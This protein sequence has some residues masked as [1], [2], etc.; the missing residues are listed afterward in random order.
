MVVSH[1]TEIN[2]QVT[3]VH[4]GFVL[5][6]SP[7]AGISF[8]DKTFL[9]EVEVRSVTRAANEPASFVSYFMDKIARLQGY[10]TI[11]QNTEDF[12]VAMFTELLRTPHGRYHGTIPDIQEA[13]MPLT[14]E[15]V[16]LGGYQAID[17]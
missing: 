15:L 4:T 16:S 8:L 2:E 14:R 5:T 13:Y 7:L 17:H 1:R 11:A 3:H 10:R 12:V 6:M 9:Q